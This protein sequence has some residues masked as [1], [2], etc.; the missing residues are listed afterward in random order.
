MR[1]PD[2]KANSARMGN[3]SH[4]LYLRLAAHICC[5]TVGK[6]LRRPLVLL[7]HALQAK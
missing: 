1:R 2:A 6:L 5:P 7:W 3:G 4:A